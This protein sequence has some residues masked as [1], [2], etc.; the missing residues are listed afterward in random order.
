VFVE[1][2]G[3]EKPWND[4]GCGGGGGGGDGGGGAGFPLYFTESTAT[5]VD[6]GCS[7]SL[8]GL[9]NI[10][11]RRS[12]S[13]FAVA[14]DVYSVLDHSL[15]YSADSLLVSNSPPYSG[16]EVLCAGTAF[17]IFDPICGPEISS[18]LGRR[19]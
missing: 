16:R 7:D 18:P 17:E 4:C 11:E 1:D 6:F 19:G 2:L 13:G 8:E 10:L 12:R 15:G 3:V 9:P 5:M 14:L